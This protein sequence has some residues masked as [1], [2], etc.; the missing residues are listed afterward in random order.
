MGLL[1]PDP[2]LVFWMIIVFGIVFA[3]LAKFGFPVI[4]KMVDDRKAYIDKSLV[5]ARQANE[6]LVNVKA[7][8]EKILMQAHEEQARILKEAKETKDLIVKEAQ[9]KAKLEGERLLE[10][11][12]KEIAT[13]KESVIRDVRRQVAVLSVGIAEKILRDKL[14]D[15]KEQT[16]LINRMLD[17]FLANK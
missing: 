6:Q 10:E 12:K 13:E 16:E 15:S 17:E 4:I 3:I 7:E 11:M 9:E 1:T 8:G 5:A 14:S 2:G